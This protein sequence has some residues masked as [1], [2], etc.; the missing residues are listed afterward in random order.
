MQKAQLAE[1]IRPAVNNAWYL[2]VSRT[3]LFVA[4]TSLFVVY[5]NAS[6]LVIKGCSHSVMASKLLH[7]EQSHVR[8][9]L[10]PFGAIAY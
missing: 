8:A 9:L 3:V 2:G 1:A 6:E 10:P 5:E 7:D 4:F